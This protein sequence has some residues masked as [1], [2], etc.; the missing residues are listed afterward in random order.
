MENKQSEQKPLSRQQRWQLKK[1]AEGKCVICGQPRSPLYDYHCE[2]HA[3]AVRKQQR[4]RM[5]C[6]KKVKGKR[7]RPARVAEG[8]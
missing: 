5:G 8:K 1:K 4:K 3:V 6:K 7:G 2:K